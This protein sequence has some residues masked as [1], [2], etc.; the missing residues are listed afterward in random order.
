M[1]RFAVEKAGLDVNTRLPLPGNPTLIHFFTHERCITL[2]RYLLEA[3]AD[4]RLGPTAEEAATDI[5]RSAVDAAQILLYSL[6]VHL[7][8]AGPRRTVE[9]LLEAMRA[10][11]DRLDAENAA[12]AAPAGECASERET[13]E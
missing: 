10:A 11:A 4:P 3:G 13:V 6:Q 8:G 7:P 2:A 12:A 1:L 9:A 5:G